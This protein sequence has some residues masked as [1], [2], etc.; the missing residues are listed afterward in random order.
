VSPLRRT[1]QTACLILQNYANKA[2]LIIKL[3]PSLKEFM[4][5]QNTLLVSKSALLSFCAD[6]STKYSLQ[7]DCSFLEPF[8]EYWFWE[9][10]PSKDKATELLSIVPSQS[11]LSMGFDIDVFTKLKDRA[12]MVLPGSNETQREMFVRT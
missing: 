1:I 11:D 4:S 7:I 8:G 10:H 6:M 2:S 5:Y 12:M 3:D 9:S